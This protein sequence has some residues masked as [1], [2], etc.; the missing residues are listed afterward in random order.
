M[1]YRAQEPIHL[2]GMFHLI[3]TLSTG[4][5]TKYAF[6]IFDCTLQ[7]LLDRLFGYSDEITTDYV[8]EHRD[9]L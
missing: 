6:N 7:F 4:N 5:F 8:L 3:V 2:G 9:V 1:Q